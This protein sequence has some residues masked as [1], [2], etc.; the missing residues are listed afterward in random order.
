[1]T[2]EIMLLC[3]TPVCPC[4]L[5]DSQN[6]PRQP[7]GSTATIA[8]SLLPACPRQRSSQCPDLFGPPP[9]YSCQDASCLLRLSPRSLM[10]LHGPASSAPSSPD[11]RAPHPLPHL[12]PHNFR[13]L[14]DPWRP[15]VSLVLSLETAGQSVELSPSSGSHPALCPH[16]TQHP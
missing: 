1:M 9:L 14:T 2:V 15:S 3:P 7:A 4:P 10:S 5:P 12:P 13:L 8:I 6:P 11:L 16:T